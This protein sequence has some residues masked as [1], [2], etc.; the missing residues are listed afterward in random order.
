MVLATNRTQQV[1]RFIAKT[2][3]CD[4]HR[5]VIAGDASARQYLRLS[6]ARESVIVMDAPPNN[7]ED[8]E[9]FAQMAAF[10]N[11][12]GLSVPDVLSHDR[13]NGLMILR[14]LG[15]DDF[16]HWLNIH[17]MDQTDLYKAAID[18]LVHVDAI[19]PPLGL[20][21]MTPEV[22]A[23]MVG[24]VCEH[25][26]SADATDITQEMERALTNFAPNPT[27][28][29]LRDYHAENLIWRPDKQGLGRVGLLDFQDAFIAPAGYDLASLLRD[30]RRDIPQHIA[31]E[32]I[33]YFA[34]QTNM[35]KGFRT[36][37][38]CLGVQR[39]LRILGVFARLSKVMGKTR[40]LKFIP[41]VWDHIT[42]DLADPALSDL[43]RTVTEILPAPTD[44]LLE[45]LR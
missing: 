24:I 21:A 34:A 6:K 10:L 39:N 19:S 8:T 4:W 1:D 35:H 28:L 11:K 43:K 18:V 16:A 31:D 27:T 42:H 22:G 38:A 33:N 5:S 7:G 15:P 40:Y 32:M 36:Q 44:Q 17:P 37:V 41:R 25:Y 2:P 23:Q 9:P 26:C 3:W 20:T 30:A 29:A 14:D 12:N 45:G 13:K